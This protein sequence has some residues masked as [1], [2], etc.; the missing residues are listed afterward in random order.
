MRIPMEQNR[1]PRSAASAAEDMDTGDRAS[2]D[3]R[4]GGDDL[5]ASGE[6]G[7]E[8]VEPGEVGGVGV[9]GVE[10]GEVSC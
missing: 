5:A 1:R 3:G 4:S 8:F 6:L 7:A 9:V 10:P 2:L